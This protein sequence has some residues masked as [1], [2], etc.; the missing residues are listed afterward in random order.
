MAFSENGSCSSILHPDWTAGNSGFTAAQAPNPAGAPP[1]AR[2]FGPA[3]TQPGF[4]TSSAGYL[5]GPDRESCRTSQ[6]RPAAT[7]A[8]SKTARA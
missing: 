2:P 1:W 4:V 6:R 7:H 8:T 3:L 5:E